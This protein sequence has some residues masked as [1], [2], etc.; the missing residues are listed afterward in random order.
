MPSVEFHVLSEAG[1]NVR[2]RYVCNLVERAYEQAQRVFVRTG[3]AAETQI[4][5]ELLWTFSDRAFIPHEIA[6][7]NSPSD[8]HIA[9]L[10]GPGEAPEAYRALLINL[11]ADL[12]ADFDR[13]ARVAEIVDA[14]AERKKLARER[15]KQYRDRGCSLE[16]INR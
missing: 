15:Y 13:Y 11:A 8:P 10:I 2:N 9:A 12:P 5:D 14:D 6:T 4:L 1:E 16:T 3:T 7:A